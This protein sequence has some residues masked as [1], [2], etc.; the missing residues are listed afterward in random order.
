MPLRNLLNRG[1]PLRRQPHR[2][3]VLISSTDNM[4]VKRDIAQYGAA[5]FHHQ[6][7]G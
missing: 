5:R 6:E 1:E 3:T 4:L 7:G 2:R